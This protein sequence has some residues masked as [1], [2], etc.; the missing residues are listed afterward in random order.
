MIIDNIAHYL[1]E[2]VETIDL[3]LGSNIF[4]A[5]MPD[6]PAE[7][8]AVYDTGGATPDIDIPTGSPTFQI[9]VRTADYENG[10]NLMKEIV[11]LLHQKMNITL[12]EGGTYFYSIFLMGEAGH[13]GR[14]EKS[15]DEF[16]VNF[17][18]KTR[19]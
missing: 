3:T 6:T 13:I 8:V 18:C 10:F 19:R 17:I 2:N 15:R 5:F 11:D 16:S 9:I 7:I 14:D 4:T 12:A 1:V